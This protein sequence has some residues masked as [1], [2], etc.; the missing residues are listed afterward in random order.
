MGRGSYSPGMRIW[1]NPSP[2]PTP[3]LPLILP[4]VRAGCAISGSLGVFWGKP[5][6]IE[7]NPLTSLIEEGDIWR[8]WMVWFWGGKAEKRG[9]GG[10]FAALPAVFGLK[11]PADKLQIPRRFHFPPGISARIIKKDTSFRFG[12]YFVKTI[13]NSA[14][15]NVFGI[16]MRGETGK[17]CANV[18]L[19]GG[20]SAKMPPVRKKV[21]HF[22]VAF[23]P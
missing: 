7:G 8:G 1:Q 15:L 9:K 21:R 5:L 10:R 13:Q 2:T 16:R 12:K 22:Y 17:N 3:P 23:R 11:L 18:C 6:L 4:T 20:K 14:R 19:A